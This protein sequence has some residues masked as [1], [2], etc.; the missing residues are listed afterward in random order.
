MGKN[1]KKENSQWKNNLILISILI[2]GLTF[3][4]SLSEN[5]LGKWIRYNFYFRPLYFFFSDFLYAPY[6][7]TFL[8]ILLFI[9]LFVIFSIYN[10][11]STIKDKEKIFKI[12]R[13]IFGCLLAMSCAGLV[14]YLSIMPDI[15]YIAKKKYLIEFSDITRLEEYIY[16]GN[17]S[18]YHQYRLYTYIPD[19]NY[20]YQNNESDSW[21]N[22]RPY[23]NTQAEDNYDRYNHHGS[24]KD[25]SCY[26]HLKLNEYQYR[27]LKNYQSNISMSNSISYKKIKLYYLPNNRVI[28]KYEIMN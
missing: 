19:K 11:Y 10:V 27:E 23:S 12:I 18:T 4:I 3:C 15:E 8:P 6:F 21:K 14:I 26:K 22:R 24:R 17:R 13:A 5:D 25:L 9:I 1:Q 20:E 28:L 7:Y 16:V 2:A